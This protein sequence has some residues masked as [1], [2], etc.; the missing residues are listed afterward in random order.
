MVPRGTFITKENKATKIDKIS[1]LT[2]FKHT[3]MF[4]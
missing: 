1:I 2:I 3:S 4:V